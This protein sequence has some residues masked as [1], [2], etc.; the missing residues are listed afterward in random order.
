MSVDIRAIGAHPDDIEMICGG[1]IAKMIDRGYTAAIIDMTRGESGTRGTPEQ[2]QAEADAAAKV[3]GVGERINL[4]QPDSRMSN[5]L[6]ARIAVVEQIRRLR[7]KIV[8]T[9]WW[10]DL[11]PDHAA[12]GQIVRD[13]MYPAGFANF[14]A[15]GQPFRPNEYLFFMA[16]FPFEP[17]FIVDIEGYWEQ[18]VESIL[19][20]GS[21]LH[22][23]TVDGLE[24]FISE[25]TFMKR[26]EGRA[27]HY[28]NQIYREFGE[29]FLVRR[30]V[31]V[32][33]PIN[34]YKPFTKV[35]ASNN[36]NPAFGDVAGTK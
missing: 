7:P 32:D 35:H 11:H 17:S 30:P 1:T 9:H 33:D 5:T 20:Y 27:R 21:Q 10:E 34:L 24:T 23:S 28:G 12:T 31:P 4:Q 29:P 13:T 14:P 8:M 2:R 3:L 6:E 19:C 15:K 16:H 36:T 25:P 26:L 18:K 22:D